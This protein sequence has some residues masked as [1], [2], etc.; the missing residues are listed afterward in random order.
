MNWRAV[1]P[2]WVLLSGYP[3]AIIH[4]LGGA[5]VGAAPQ[6]SYGKLL[7]TLAAE[8]YVIIATPFL[9]TLDHRAIA[10]TVLQ[11]F[12]TTVAELQQ[13][14]LLQ[15]HLPIYGLGHSLGCK[16]HLLIGSFFDVDRAGNMLMAFNNFNVDRAIP[17][18]DWLDQSWS[19]EFT[20]TPAQTYQLI[21]DYYPIDQNLLIRFQNDE[22]DQ[23]PEIAQLLDHL[24]PGKIR[25]KRLPGNH[26]TPLGQDFRWQSP[27][28]FSPL[29]A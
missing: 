15:R 6:L 19:V 16:L 21:Q 17:L 12:E 1:G 8:G 11:Q 7:E 23:T 27:E 22:L 25:L 9:N 14:Q 28:T 18:A 24:F 20:P 5:F 13:R 29:D 2:N 26:L 3:V 10:H 4:F